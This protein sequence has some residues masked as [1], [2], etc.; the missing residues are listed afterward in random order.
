MGIGIGGQ[1]AY[2]A[3][4]YMMTSAPPG[5]TI[6]WARTDC[7]DMFVQDAGQYIAGDFWHDNSTPGGTYGGGRWV[8]GVQC[9]NTQAVTPNINSSYYAFQ[10]VCEV[11]PVRTATAQNAISGIQLHATETRAPDL[12]AQGGLWDDTGR[13]V[14]GSWSIPVNASDPSGVCNLHATESDG[15]SQRFIQGPSS[16]LDQTHGISARISPGVR[17]RPL[18]QAPRWLTRPRAIRAPPD[19]SP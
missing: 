1:P 14:R 9:I 10:L 5:I 18:R 4:G 8:N 6:N 13:Y 3:R 19:R 17:A 7:R 11:K 15:K 2:Q 12:S 16:G